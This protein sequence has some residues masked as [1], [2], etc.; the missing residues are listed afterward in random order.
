VLSNQPAGNAVLRF[1][2]QRDGSLVQA[3]SYPTGGT[4]TGGGLGSQGAVTLDDSD[5][6]LYAVNPGSA[7][8]SS[9]RV[10]RDGLELVDV[11]P[12]GGVMPTSVTVHGDLVQANDG[13]PAACSWI[14]TGGLQRYPR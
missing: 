1:E 11:V 8:L 10:Q 3:G 5:R 4:G 14:P 9:F 13:R 2:R 6:Y 12:S 7:T